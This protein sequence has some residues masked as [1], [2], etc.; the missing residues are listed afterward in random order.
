MYFSPLQVE[1]NEGGSFQV[2]L[3][4]DAGTDVSSAPLQI[5]YDPKVLSLNDVVRGGFLSSDGQS[6]VFTK[7]ILNE[8]GVAAVQ[9]NRQPGTPGVN[10]SG[11]LVTLN[12]R[13]LAKGNTTVTIPNFTLR[14]SQGVVIT[15]VTPQ[16]NVTIK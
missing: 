16:L 3:S 6:P 7:N 15:T 8:M 5:Q 4:L 13:A 14:N 12:F 10:G 9:L 11:P 2:T 1:A